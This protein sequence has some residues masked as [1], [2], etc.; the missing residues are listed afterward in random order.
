MYPTTRTR[1]RGARGVLTAAALAGLLATATAC[2]SGGSGGG[3][4]VSA[5]ADQTIVL[6]AAGLGSEGDAT[7]AAIASFEQLYPNIKVQLLSLSSDENDQYT[8]I[9][10]RFSAKSAT[11]DVIAGDVIWTATFAAAGWVQDL[12]GDGIAT[13]DF[14]PGQLSSGQYNGKLYAV[15]WFV[16][17]EGIYYRT[18]LVKSP[19][20][21]PDQLVSDAKAALAADPSLQEG[22]AWEGDKYEGSVTALVSFMGGFGGSLNPKDLNT[23]ANQQTLQYMYDLIHSDSVTPQAALGWQE[24]NVQDAWTSGQAAFALN[25]PY[26]YQLSEASGSSVAGKTAWI[27]FPSPKGS[28]TAALGGDNLMVNAR[29]SHQAA[30]V[31]LIQY[32]TSDSVQDVRATAAGD[33]PSVESAYNSQLYATAPYYQQE[34]S[35]FAAATPRPVSPVYPQMSTIFQNMISEVLSGQDSPSAALASAQT[36]INQ[37]PQ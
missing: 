25:W 4:Q 36:Q 32:L 7:K 23:P 24:S 10:Q 5:S 3:S 37:I 18:D 30:A 15:P 11:P 2:S 29:S 14:F 8:Q 19:P 16:N 34:K 6:A 31:K 9:T 1:R 13:K 12:S 26:L 22:F 27:P 28:P 35:V 17:A 21:T 20:T 33:P